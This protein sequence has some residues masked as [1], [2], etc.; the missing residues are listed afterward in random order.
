MGRSAPPSLPPLGLPGWTPWKKQLDKMWFS[1]AESSLSNGSQ[2]RNQPCS[3]TGRDAPSTLKPSSVAPSGP[4]ML[5][6]TQKGAHCTP[7]HL[8]P[9]LDPQKDP[10]SPPGTSLPFIAGGLEGRSL[11]PRLHLDSQAA[12]GRELRPSLSQPTARSLSGQC[13]FPPPGFVAMATLHKARL[14]SEK[15]ILS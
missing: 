1:L 13:D 4:L 3:N 10:W 5:A 8:T 12:R 11:C 15:S 9:C 2:V 14:P 7:G 6:L